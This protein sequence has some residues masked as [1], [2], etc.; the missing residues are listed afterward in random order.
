M[1]LLQNLYKATLLYRHADA[2][3][4]NLS[5]KNGAKRTTKNHFPFAL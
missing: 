2:I 5:K 1:K 4:K 3:V